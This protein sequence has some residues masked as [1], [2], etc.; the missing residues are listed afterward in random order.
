MFVSVSASPTFSGWRTAAA[1]KA[2]GAR[3]NG[4]GC[5]RTL[6]RHSPLGRGARLAFRPRSPI[7]GAKLRSVHC[8]AVP[9]GEEKVR[10]EQERAMPDAK[11]VAKELFTLYGPV[12]LGTSLVFAAISFVLFYALVSAGV[13]IR[14]FIDGLGNLLAKT[15]IGRPAA[16]DQ[17]P[18]QPVDRVGGAGASVERSTSSQVDRNESGCAFVQSVSPQVWQRE[19]K[20]NDTRHGHKVLH[21]ATGKGGHPYATRSLSACTQRGM[22]PLYRTERPQHAFLFTRSPIGFGQPVPL[23]DHSSNQGMA[24]GCSTRHTQQSSATESADAGARLAL[25]AGKWGE[26]SQRLV[27][28]S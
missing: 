27:A 10:D 14:Q 21:A 16:L 28:A 5:Q 8:S 26:R 25:G 23:C 11:Q 3:V 17:I 9:P 6:R 2:G 12:Y 13:D 18:P 22:R 7:P 24:Q 19:M 20:P 4:E 1:V 15:P